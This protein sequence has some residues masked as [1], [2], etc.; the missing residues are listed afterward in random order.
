MGGVL[1]VF[2]FARNNDSLLRL[3]KT[4]FRI[5]ILAEA[6]L[7][8][9]SELLSNISSSV[10]IILYNFQLLR[11]AGDDGVAAYGVI[12]YVGF[13]FIA[14]FIG[15]SVGIAPVIGYNYGADNRAEMKNILGK[16]ILLL[17]LTQVAMLLLCAFLSW[18]ISALFVGYDKALMSLT[19]HAMRIYAFSYLFCGFSIFGSS[20][21]TALGNGPVSAAISFMRTLVFQ[22]LFV[23]L[24][25]AIFGLN[26]IW[27]AMIAAE[28]AAFAVTVAFILAKRKK[29]GYI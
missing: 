10:V 22:V 19:V 27:F 23:F 13:I 15:Y 29:Y 12:G 11:L 26:G 1:P 18:P 3:G 6:C 14:V 21:F 20:F 17:S 9:S 4:N 5:K 24:M 8:G 2:Y 28:G 25:P 16:S 7:N